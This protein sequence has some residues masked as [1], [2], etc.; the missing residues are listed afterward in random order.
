MLR[1]A[2]V[3]ARACV[4]LVVVLPKSYSRNSKIHVFGAVR[5]V[6]STFLFPWVKAIDT[7][8]DLREHKCRFTRHMKHSLLCGSRI[9]NAIS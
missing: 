1:I 7:T 5:E 8:F 9:T 2:C 6:A 3:H 4:Q